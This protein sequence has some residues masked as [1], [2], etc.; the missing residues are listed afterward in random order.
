MIKTI[1][2]TADKNPVILPGLWAWALA[3][4]AKFFLS[5]TTCWVNSDP[6][7]SAKIDLMPQNWF[8]CYN[9]RPI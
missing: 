8:K 1:L 6:I 5:M 9:F 3:V 7:E 2:P 4:G